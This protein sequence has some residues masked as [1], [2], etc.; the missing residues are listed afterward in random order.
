MKSYVKHHPPS[1]RAIG[2]G[3]VF[4]LG[5]LSTLGSGGGNNNGGSVSGEP[6]SSITAFNFD[7]G[8]TLD[9]A[10][11]AAS[12]MAFFPNFTS[13]AR[14]IQ[15]T[16]AAS[17]PDN[18]PFDISMSMC[19]NAGHAMLTWIDADHSGNLSMGDSAALLLT[20]CDLDRSGAAATGTVKLGITNVHTTPPP[21]SVGVNVSVNLTVNK[22]PD[23]TT[24]TGNFK[25]TSSTA[26][27]TDFTYTYTTSDSAA[28]KLIATKNGGAL[29]ELGCFNVTE[30]FNIADSAGTYKLA[31]SGV[32]NAAE[33]LMSLADGGHL[34]FISNHLESGS[35]HLLSSST[36]ACAAV[37]AP[38]GADG[39]DGSHID[40]EALGGDN[41]RLHTFDTSNLEIST[42][43]TAWNALLN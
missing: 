16:L 36:P 35:Q 8:N 26:N 2:G 13:T 30:T 40:M 1:V 21:D 25:A 23:T 29:F 22:A 32:V 42:T 17:S 12:A 39:A 14:Q 4:L 15:T 41:L 6:P 27:N 19:A 10:R 24:L 20:N 3:L 34:A 18:S 7:A 37:G 11:S 9:A 31:S 5:I 38:G 43:D 28:Q 33:S